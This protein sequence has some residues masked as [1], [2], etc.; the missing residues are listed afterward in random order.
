MKAIIELCSRID[1]AL[2]AVINVAVTVLGFFIAFSMVGGIVFRALLGIQVFGLEEL[3]LMA[4]MWL[5]ML[6]AALASRERSHLSADFFQ[7]FS[8]NEVLH[9]VMRLI[10]T[11]LSLVMAVFFVNWSYSLFSWGFEKGQVTPVFGIPQYFSQ[12]SLLVASVLLLLYV[13]RDF[14]H[15]VSKMFR[16]A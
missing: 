16:K 13:L 14:V 3:V 15:D 12:V 6:G 10:A 9:D 11:G 1:N 2:A 5:Y 8:D 4:A 7:A